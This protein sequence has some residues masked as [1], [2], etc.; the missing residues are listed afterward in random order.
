MWAYKNLNIKEI[1]KTVEFKVL[2]TY[3]TVMCLYYVHIWVIVQM[4]L[5]T[6]KDFHA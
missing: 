1:Y 4:F 6:S 2:L 5:Q 3:K